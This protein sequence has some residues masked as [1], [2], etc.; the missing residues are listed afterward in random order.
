MKQNKDDRI[1]GI[2]GGVGAGKS[3]ILSYLKNQYD[4]Y[5]LEADAVGHQVQQPGEACWERIV[6]AFGEEILREDRTIDRGKLGSIVYAD[7]KKLEQL[8]AIV[9]PAV[10]M[11]ILD[12]IA[13]I[14]KFKTPS[15]STGQPYL[16]AEG[17]HAVSAECKSANL[18]IVIEAALLL[19]ANYDAI[20]DEV[21]YIFADEQ[22]RA[23]RLMRSRGYSREKIKQI[24]ANQLSEEEFR[25][26]C[27]AVIDNSCSDTAEAFAQ[28]DR[29][30]SNGI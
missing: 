17:K 23:E 5:I 11:R 20:C 2:T 29:I 15:D 26:R 27:D 21:W 19:E 13:R 16:P 3:T 22:T 10:K 30:L 24:M 1:I 12:E 28:I 8:N 18:L 25:H 9:H 6:S 4:A 14:R 7:R